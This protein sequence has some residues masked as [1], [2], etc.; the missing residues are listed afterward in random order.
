MR[1]PS[2]NALHSFFLIS[3]DN[4]YNAKVMEACGLDRVPDRRTFDRKLKNI[5][6]YGSD[7]D[8]RPRI[9]AMGHLFVA[10]KLVD[11]YIAS[12]D[13]TLLKAK[14]HV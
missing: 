12:V 10:E 2:N 3:V 6:T 1:I 4:R 14:E 8:L 9:D 13:S 7:E 11:P 5:A